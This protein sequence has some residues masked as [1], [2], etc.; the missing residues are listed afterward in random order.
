MRVAEDAGFAWCGVLGLAW[1][2]V[3]GITGRTRV[4]HENGVGIFFGGR[5]GITDETGEARCV[6]VDSGAEIGRGNIGTGE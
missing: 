1:S 4:I 2:G 5:D 3:V 6:L